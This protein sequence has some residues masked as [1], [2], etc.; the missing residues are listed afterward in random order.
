MS[1]IVLSNALR[2]NLSSIKSTADLLSRTQDRLSTGL[3]VSSAIDNPTSFFTAQGLNNRAA[4]LGKLLDDIGQSIDTLKAAD[5][6]IKGI[7]KL[8]ENLKA[9]A[10]QALSTKITATDITGSTTGLASTDTVSTTTG[11]STGNTF[12]IQVGDAAAVAVT[13]GASTSSL[14]N[15]VAAIGGVTNVTASIT[16]DGQLKVEATNGEDLTIADTA[17]TAANALGIVGTSTNGTNR[18]TFVSDFNTL[19]TQIDQLAADASF[20]GVNLLQA[21][22]NLTV[23]FNEDQTASLTISS[24]LL[25]TSA[26]GLNVGEESNANFATDSNI[27]S[28]IK[29]LDAAV[30]TLRNQASSFGNNLA[31]VENRQNFTN[32]LIDT[33]QTGAA[34]L[35]LADTNEEGANLLALQTRQQLGTTAL[36]LSAQADQNVLRLF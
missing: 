34:K 16:S 15:L 32:A 5:E 27:E 30:T 25:D 20:K 10:S 11:V 6:G 14:G 13:V 9:T 4:D 35:T 23:N 19:R 22:N 36:S 18:N 1:D 12:T 2:S 31:I 33:L 28:T 24:K 21:N 7:T 29:T 3:K 26:S 17:G 8:V